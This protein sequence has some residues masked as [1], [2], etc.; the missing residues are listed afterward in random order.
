MTE[1]APTENKSELVLP[2][3]RYCVSLGYGLTDWRMAFEML[4]GD[5]FD[6]LELPAEVVEEK[7]LPELLSKTALSVVNVVNLT[8]QALSRGI[9]D[10]KRRSVDEFVSRTTGFIG[11]AA[12]LGITRFSMD[13]G[14]D[15]AFKEPDLMEPRIR[16]L[17]QFSHCLVRH[18]A[19]IC[20]PVRAPMI[21][22]LSAG[23]SK[24]LAVL[25]DSMYGGFRICLSVYPHQLKRADNPL[26]I[27]KWYQF[28]LDLVR[29]VY[30]PETGNH[31]TGPL[32]RHWLEPLDSIG[33]NGPV[34]ICPMTSDFQVFEREVSKIVDATFPA[35]DA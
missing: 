27:L 32:M 15:M 12:G 7:E 31:L 6:G 26:D 34:V 8:N 14:F 11:M 28:D 3:R 5:L 16:L 1:S 30:E 24:M 10:H 17:K 2:R 22:D 4:H 29:I 23:A 25:R 9:A 13:F 33:Y 19:V 20:L 21:G 35:S 18:N